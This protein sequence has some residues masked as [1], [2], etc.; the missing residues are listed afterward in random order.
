MTPP[1]PRRYGM[2]I[3]S[4]LTAVLALVA[5]VSVSG[6][7]LLVVPFA[8]VVGVSAWKGLTLRQTGKAMSEAT[9]DDP[10]HGPA[11]MSF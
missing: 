5:A 9:S 7:A 4:A 3:V 6:W 8:L 10:G 1:P 11:G 2:V